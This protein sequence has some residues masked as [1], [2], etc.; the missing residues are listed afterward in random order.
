MSHQAE[1]LAVPSIR[2]IGIHPS[3]IDKFYDKE[4]QIDLTE[5]DV[6]K[7]NDIINRPYIK[8][9]P[10]LEKEIKILLD[11]NCKAEIEGIETVP[12]YL[13]NVYLR[14]KIANGDFL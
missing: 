8:S 4:H 12:A 5:K 9:D 10:L 11:R 1:Q 2:W 6:G 3:E 7:L 14:I 13:V